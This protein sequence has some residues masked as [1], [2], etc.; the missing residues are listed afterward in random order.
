M[1]RPTAIG[2]QI[3]ALASLFWV[4]VRLKEFRKICVLHAVIDLRLTENSPAVLALGSDDK[5]DLS[6]CQGRQKYVGPMTRLSSL[7]DEY[8]SRLP[9]VTHMLGWTD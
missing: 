6:P 3:A 5:R 4:V 1:V 2:L 9:R 7:T 8:L